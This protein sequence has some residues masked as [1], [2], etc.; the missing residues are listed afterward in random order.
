[1][2]EGKTVPVYGDGSNVRDWLYVDDHCRAIDLIINQGRVGEVYNIGGNA[3]RQNIHIVQMIIK[4]IREMIMLNPDYQ[5]L[6]KKKAIGFD[7]RLSFDRINDKLITFV[8]DRLGHDQ[9]YAIDSSKI[10]NELGWIP[11]MNFESGL[12]ET[13]RW[14]FD[15]QAWVEQIVTGDYVNYYERMYAGR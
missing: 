7:E 15:N 5:S 12:W 2:L 4:K 10:K 14:Y 13:I 6:P 11:N 3:E 1:M 9:R 8:T